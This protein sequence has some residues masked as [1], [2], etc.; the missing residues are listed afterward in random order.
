MDGGRS[1]KDSSSREQPRNGGDK[2]PGG[3][4]GWRDEGGE[5]EEDMQCTGGGMQ[6]N[7]M[8]G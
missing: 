4:I 5:E 2:T 8:D 7:A 6:Q 3:D 1:K